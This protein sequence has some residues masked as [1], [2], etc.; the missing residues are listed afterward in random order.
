MSKTRLRIQNLISFLFLI[1]YIYLRKALG[2]S[3]R[4]TLITSNKNYYQNYKKGTFTSP[5]KPKIFLLSA[6][7]YSILVT[8]KKR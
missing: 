8:R 5:H 1:G 3:F 2:S 4:T 7:Y 6:P